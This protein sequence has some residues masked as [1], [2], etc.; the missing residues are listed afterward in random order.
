M[1]M[2]RKALLAALAAGLAAV[3]TAYPDGFTEAE[4][5]TIL[6]AALIAGVGVWRIPN[7][8]P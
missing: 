4:T 3:G 6:A 1:S 7:E 5:A 2:I 8:E